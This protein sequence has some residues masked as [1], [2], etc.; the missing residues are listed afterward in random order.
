MEMRLMEASAAYRELIAELALQQGIDLVGVADIEEERRHF[1]ALTGPVIALLPRAVSLAVRVSPT[2]LA[3]L[4]GG[5][6]HLYYH[7]YRQLNYLLDRA[8]LALAR[9]IEALGYRA[10]AVAASQVVNWE[11]QLGHI[12]H[13]DI[14][15]RAGLGWWGRNNLL[16]TP[17][18]GA[19]VRLAT[20]L[21]D[22]PLEPG[23][24][25]DRNC[26]QCRRCLAVCPAG[27][28]K[29]DLAAFDRQACLA[30]LKEFSKTRGIG[31]QI[32]GLCVRACPGK[33]QV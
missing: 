23:K 2:V 30:Q 10:L 3:T 7:H 31:Q 22:L 26:G 5:P 27:A 18:Y 13:R 32:C 4:E 25:L 6:N 24:P 16:V 28:I 12:S 17:Q 20:V 11:E 33:G 21:T 19:Q 9:K 14:A 29:Q 1:H 15:V 8:G